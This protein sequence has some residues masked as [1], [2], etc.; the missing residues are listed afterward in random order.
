MPALGC[1]SA[2]STGAVSVA[3]TV[4]VTVAVSVAVTVAV[5]QA[6]RNKIACI[7]LLKRHCQRTFTRP[8]PLPLPLQRTYLYAFDDKDKSP[9][10]HPF[11]R[12]GVGWRWDD[13]RCAHR[14]VRG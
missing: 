10:R 13:G 11:H 9:C 2:P 6:S 14:S 7:T 8:E 5:H 12:V 4:A 1:I 3:V